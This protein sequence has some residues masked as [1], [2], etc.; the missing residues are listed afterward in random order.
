VLE[1]MHVLRDEHVVCSP[2]VDVR[3]DV[4][5]RGL[6]GP[7]CEELYGLGCYVEVAMDAAP[8]WK[9]KS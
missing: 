8:T 3:A 7:A 6:R 1:L 5:M 4:G 9:D 2:D